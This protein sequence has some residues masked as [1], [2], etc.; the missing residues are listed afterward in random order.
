VKETKPHRTSGLRIIPVTQKMSN[1]H[2]LTELV[3]HRMGHVTEIPYTIRETYYTTVILQRRSLNT[4]QSITKYLTLTIYPVTL[5]YLST[6][7]ADTH[8][9]IP[10]NI[11]EIFI[12]TRLPY[13]TVKSINTTITPTKGSRT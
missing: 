3:I 1:G 10:D 13:T 9:S 8:Q 4:I 12:R 2:T 7:T 5:H 6:Y 11:L